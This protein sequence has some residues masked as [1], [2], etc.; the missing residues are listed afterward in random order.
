MHD[1]WCPTHSAT[2]IWEAETN[3]WKPFHQTHPVRY[4][5][6]GGGKWV[7]LNK[8]TSLSGRGAVDIQL[9]AHE[10]ELGGI[11]RLGFFPETPSRP[12]TAIQHGDMRFMCALTLDQGLSQQALLNAVATCAPSAGT[13]GSTKNNLLEA[14]RQFETIEQRF[15]DG[16]LVRAFAQHASDRICGASPQKAARMGSELGV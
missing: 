15:E 9:K 11:S 4:P 14:I 5:V 2:E 10:N 13:A 16:E 3:S 12:Q 6:E 7:H 1:R 8:L